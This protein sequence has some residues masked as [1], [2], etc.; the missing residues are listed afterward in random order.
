MRKLPLIRSLVLSLLFSV[1]L[2][3]FGFGLNLARTGVNLLNRV[4]LLN[5]LSSYFVF[6]PHKK[7]F[8]CD[9]THF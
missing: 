1:V 3:G 9:F 8:K 5:S 4:I 7:A 2:T 6:V